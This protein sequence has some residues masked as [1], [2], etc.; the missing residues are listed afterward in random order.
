[1]QAYATHLPGTAGCYISIYTF[2]KLSVFL[3]YT[4]CMCNG[5][6]YTL[7]MY[8]V[9]Y[10]FSMFPVFYTFSRFPVFYTFSM[11]PVFYTFPVFPVFYTFSMSP[12]FSMFCMLPVFCKFCIL[13]D[14]PY[15]QSRNVV[16]KKT[17]LIIIVYG[18]C[19]LYH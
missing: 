5:M 18:L 9:F 14:A 4:I 10:T 6:F 8:L 13:R 11:F 2:H 1:M 17:K 19:S 3:C 12:V 15:N 16:L 7:S